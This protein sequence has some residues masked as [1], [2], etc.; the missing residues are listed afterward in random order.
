MKMFFIIG[1]GSDAGGWIW[2]GHKFRRIP[3][4]NP[5]ELVEITRAVDI[6]R[7]VRQ[8]KTPGLA[9]A[10]AGRLTE[11]VQKEL[12]QHIEEGGILVIA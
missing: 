1:G 5:E 11:F 12:S 6:I 2:D 9:E 8:F 10:I 3:G 4:W 7:Q